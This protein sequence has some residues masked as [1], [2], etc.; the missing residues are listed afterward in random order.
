MTSVARALR[1]I[2]NFQIPPERIDATILAA[3][4]VTLYVKSGGDLRA[5]E[6]FC[7]DCAASRGRPN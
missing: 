3:I 6:G 5:S 2:A 7:D 1:T 4:N